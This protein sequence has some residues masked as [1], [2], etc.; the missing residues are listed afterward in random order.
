LILVL[1]GLISNSVQLF[2]KLYYVDIGITIN[3]LH[4]VLGAG[5]ALAEMLS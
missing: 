3:F 2:N 1:N 4:K 5:T